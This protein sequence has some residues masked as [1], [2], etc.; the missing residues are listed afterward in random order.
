MNKT[1]RNPRNSG[2]GR[3]VFDPSNEPERNLA[4]VGIVRHNQQTAQADRS[5]WHMSGTTYQASR[6]SWASNRPI[7]SIPTELSQT[8][9]KTR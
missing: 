4:T 7:L 2:A 5:Q 3:S 9:T 6:I 8:E 1:P